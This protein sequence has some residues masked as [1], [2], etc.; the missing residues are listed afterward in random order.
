MASEE[1]VDCIV[2]ERPLKGDV[3]M[4]LQHE[5]EW[6]SICCPL[7]FEKFDKNK[8]FYTSR[9]RAYE[10]I[11]TLQERKNNTKK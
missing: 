11:D 7:C 2:C 5:G 6:I 9:R 4:R 8:N 3:Y 10:S 1:N